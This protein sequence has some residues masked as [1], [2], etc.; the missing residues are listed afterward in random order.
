MCTHAI[1]AILRA[2]RFPESFIGFLSGAAGNTE[3]RKTR[4]LTEGRRRR[5]GGEECASLKRIER[6]G[7]RTSEKNKRRLL[8]RQGL[9]SRRPRPSEYTGM[10][11]VQVTRNRYDRYDT[12]DNRQPVSPA[13]VNI[14]RG[15]SGIH[16]FLSAADTVINRVSPSYCRWLHR[17]AARPPHRAAPRRV[18]RPGLLFLYYP[19]AT[20]AIPF[21][22]DRKQRAGV[23]ALLLVK[24]GFIS[25]RVNNRPLLW[26]ARTIAPEDVVVS[27]AERKNFLEARGDTCVSRR[28]A[29]AVGGQRRQARTIFKFA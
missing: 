2:I 14:R 8:A 12:R 16:L 25:R 15:L 18:A 21:I 28:A 22:R 27:P 6:S 10:S 1:A 26:R 13:T 9:P 11:Q 7:Y 20:N 24:P 4:I 17:R 23:I 5:R 29:A 3:R 19:A